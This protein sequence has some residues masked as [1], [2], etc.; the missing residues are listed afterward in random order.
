[1]TDQETTVIPFLMK[2]GMIYAKLALNRVGGPAARVTERF[3]L[4]KDTGL[5]IQ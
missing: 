1:M 4:E 5:S 2:A 3:L